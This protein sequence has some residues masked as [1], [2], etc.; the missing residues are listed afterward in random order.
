MVVDK[1]PNVISFF[2]GCGGSS[3]G[4]KRAECNILLASDWEKKALDIYKH[5]F[6]ETQIFQADIRVVNLDVITNLTGIK[7]GE[8]DILDGSPPCTPFSTC[9]LREQGWGKS[10]IHSA[11]TKP[12]KADYLFFEF[13]RLI[14]ELKPKTFV[15]E[16]VSGLI[17]GTAKGYYKQIIQQ[18]KDIGY[19]TQSFLLNA[20]DYEVPQR[21]ERV[22]IIG[23]RNDIKQDES[24]VLKKFP[25]RISFR[26]A[27]EG[28]KNSDDEL[29]HA[30]KLSR[31]FL[32]QYISILPMGKN[33]SRFHKKGHHFNTKRE[34]FDK[35]ISTIIASSLSLVHPSENRYLTL[36]E[37]KRCAT[38]SDDFWFPSIKAGCERIGNSV[39]P[40]LMKH[41]AK[42][43]IKRANLDK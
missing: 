8:L 14:D 20:A 29:E 13:I 28:L 12:Q 21:R 1:K 39:P 40:N 32:K 4:Y 19:N 6:P 31:S 15:A 18:M 43:V 23:F 26:K 38:F 41:I 33:L 24:I 30:R 42:Y 16:N 37:V 3:L 34:S 10:Y 5:N 17:K 7:K 11:D 25:Y 27:V 2:C 9:G 22:I 36:A 35:P